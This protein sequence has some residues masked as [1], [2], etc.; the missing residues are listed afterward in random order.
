VGHRL[1]CPIISHKPEFTCLGLGT[2]SR[3]PDLGPQGLIRTTPPT[4][5][6]TAV[7]VAGLPSTICLQHAYSRRSPEGFPT[8][9]FPRPL[10]AD[11]DV[12]LSGAGR[13]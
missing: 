5:G 9:T 13:Y 3:A 1:S 4:S 10:S 11:L 12:V 7:A 8:V 6:R 2:T